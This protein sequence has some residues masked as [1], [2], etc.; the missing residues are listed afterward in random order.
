MLMSVLPSQ[1]CKEMWAMKIFFL[2]LKVS[3][4]HFHAALTL[5]MF[6][7]SL[8]PLQSNAG[9]SVLSYKHD[10]VGHVIS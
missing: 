7:V 1:A 8:E 4:S 6:K 5:W 3:R 9:I 10:L 2:Y